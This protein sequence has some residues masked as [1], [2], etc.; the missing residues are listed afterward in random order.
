M[1]QADEAV[2]ELSTNPYTH[3]EPWFLSYQ[4]FPESGRDPHAER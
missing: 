1:S 2:P 4:P 3:N